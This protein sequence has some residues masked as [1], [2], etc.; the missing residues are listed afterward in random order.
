M[1][2]NCMSKESSYKWK[3]LLANVAYFLTVQKLFL[4]TSFP[5]KLSNFLIYH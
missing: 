3:S 5:K 1:T 4:F 2:L